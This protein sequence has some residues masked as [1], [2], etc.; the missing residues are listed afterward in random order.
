MVIDVIGSPTIIPAS[1]G[2]AVA[3]GTTKNYTLVR[4]QNVVM[5]D[6]NWLICRNEWIVYP[7]GTFSYIGNF[8]NIC[9][10]A[11]DPDITFSLKS[12]PPTCGNPGYANF[13]I[14]A[15]SVPATVFN[16][17]YIY[18]K[19]TGAEFAGDD[20][21]SG[22]NLTQDTGFYYA[23][24]N[25][26]GTLGATTINDSVVEINFGS[27]A[28]PTSQNGGI[29]D[30]TPRG[31]VIVSFQIKNSCQTEAVSITDTIQSY[32]VADYS[33]IDSTYQ[34]RTLDSTV[35][36]FTT[37]CPHLCD[38]YP[39]NPYLCHGYCCSRDSAGNCVDSCYDTCYTCYL[40]CYDTTWNYNFTY[41]TTW[42]YSSI[43]LPYTN[44]YYSG[45]SNFIPV[46]C[47]PTIEP[48]TKPINAGTNDQSVPANSSMLTI[49]GAGFGS[50]K[51]VVEVPNADSGGRRLIDLDSTDIL[52]WSENRIVVKMPSV[53]LNSSG[54]P[55][56]GPIQVL[57][58][59]SIYGSSYQTLKINY[60]ITGSVLSNEKY[61]N[62]I[63]MVN[64]S[65]SLLFRCDTSISNHP[66]IYAVVQQAI[67]TWNCYTGVNWILGKDTIGDTLP[68]L[69]GVSS[70]YFTNAL[71]LGVLMETTPH[72]D[73]TCKNTGDSMA[74]VYDADIAIRQIPYPGY[75]WNYN[76]SDTVFPGNYTYF[77][78][79]LLHELGHAHQ[80]N[81]IDDSTSLMYYK[82]TLH[83]YTRKNI[84]SGTAPG[85]QT[86]YGGFDVVNTSAVNTPPC[87]F[88][89]MLVP[90][91]RTC[92]DHTLNVP[93]ISK[94]T[95]NIS[96]YP[97]PATNGNV[98]IAY[99]LNVNSTVQFK[100]TDCIG[101][102][103]IAINKELEPPGQYTEPINVN[104]L[105]QG[106]YLF[107]IEIN[108]EIQTIKFVKI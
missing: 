47:Q 70:I 3:S 101:R 97:N 33:L 29:L 78:D 25:S 46:S 102:Q 85:P 55:G 87:A 34:S 10:S 67:A 15:S 17:F 76:I 16:D 83:P 45:G 56:S 11:S 96:L 6:P 30:A 54:T 72:V 68:K 91:S 57:N 51:G 98:T 108:G 43:T 41:D 93:S 22:I 74:Y 86:L 59:C 60:N 106:I 90:S 4:K 9:S 88:Y 38:P 82:V 107:V 40:T 36:G 53:L 65:N 58:A 18:I 105:A 42:N 27:P 32:P 73:T 26:Y 49:T 48:I 64:D 8:T 20:D 94:D 12:L 1:N 19:Y 100:V 66:L 28:Y 23:P 7:Q 71:P 14:M 104:E 77:Y 50:Q 5:G 31:L 21:Y 95:Y 80:L 62:N 84:L 92:T 37:C 99:Q 13:A 35:S 63:A 2:W 39:C 61:R 69:D 103:L 24:T 81:H 44:A 75:S 89:N 52:S 79:V